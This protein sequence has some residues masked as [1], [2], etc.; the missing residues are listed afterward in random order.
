V[1]NFIWGMSVWRDGEQ[2]LWREQSGHRSKEKPKTDSK[3][4]N[5]DEEELYVQVTVHRDN[6][7]INNQ[8][9]ASSIQNFILSR[10]STCFG[11]LLCPSSGVISCTRGNWYVSCRLCGRCLGESGWNNLNLLGKQTDCPRQQPHNLHETYQLPRVQ[12][13]TP[14]DGHSRCPKHVEFRDKMKF[15]IRDASC[16]LFIRRRRRRRRKKKKKLILLAWFLSHLSTLFQLYICT[17]YIS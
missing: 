2:E 8:Q 14:D 17:C 4:C 9:D 12:L 15:W 11:H 1:S 5:A 10:D 3:G 16:W 6:L 13:I 7:R